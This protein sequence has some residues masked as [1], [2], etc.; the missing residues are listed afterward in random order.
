MFARA[1]ARRRS[2]LERA[3]VG[4]LALFVTVELIAPQSRAAFVRSCHGSFAVIGIGHRRHILEWAMGPDRNNRLDA[5]DVVFGWIG[6]GRHV[7]ALSCWSP[8]RRQSAAPPC[9]RRSI[10]CALVRRAMRSSR[11]ANVSK[12]QFVAGV[13]DVVFGAR[14]S[15]AR[16]DFHYRRPFTADR[17]EGARRHGQSYRGHWREGGKLRCGMR[18]VGARNIERRASVTGRHREQWRLSSVRPAVWPPGSVCL[19]QLGIDPDRC[20]HGSRWSHLRDKSRRPICRSEDLSAPLR[21]A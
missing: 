9:R 19:R 2:R 15:L 18:E 4:T 16:L 11:R 10:S 5:L 6:G 1:R 21:C 13:C 8:A 17:K 7:K 14:A 3:P 12:A 20:G